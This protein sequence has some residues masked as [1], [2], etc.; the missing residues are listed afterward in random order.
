MPPRKAFKILDM[1][2]NLLL[3]TKDDSGERVQQQH[4]V[5]PQ[6]GPT[7]EERGEKVSTQFGSSMIYLPSFICQIISFLFQCMTKYIFVKSI[8]IAIY[9]NVDW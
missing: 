5:I 1:N 8:G 4:N 7:S 6:V 9:Q 3:A 2:R